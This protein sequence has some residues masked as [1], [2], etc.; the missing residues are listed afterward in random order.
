MVASLS[1]VS[2]RLTFSRPQ[3]APILEFLSKWIEFFK[4]IHGEAAGAS[5]HRAAPG[6]IIDN[7]NVKGLVDRLISVRMQSDFLTLEDK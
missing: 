4:T 5:P 3:K 6:R 7:E 1:L 2:T